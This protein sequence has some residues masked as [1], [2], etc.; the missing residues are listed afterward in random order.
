MR[1]R[2]RKKRKPTAR[3][4]PSSTTTSST[5][6]WRAP[7]R[8]TSRMTTCRCRGWPSSWPS[9]GPLR[10]GRRRRRPCPARWPPRRPRSRRPAGSCPGAWPGHSPPVRHVSSSRGSR[11]SARRFHALSISAPAQRPMP[12]V[13]VIAQNKPPGPGGCG[14]G[15]SRLGRRPRPS[16]V[17][18][19]PERNSGFGPEVRHRRVAVGQAHGGTGSSISSRKQLAICRTAP[20][21]A[22]KS[23]GLVT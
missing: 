10:A 3:T 2:M 20:T 14:P 6:S 16:Q 19:P 8:T 4:T 7:S 23:G 17:P 15:R 1:M 9:G 22:S 18:A 12:P 13:S 21:K 5:T 11:R